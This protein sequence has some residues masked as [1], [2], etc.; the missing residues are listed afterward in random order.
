MKLDAARL[1]LDCEEIHE[2]Q[3]CPICSS[4]AFAYLT[5][6]IKPAVERDAE[7]RNAERPADPSPRAGYPRTSE[8]VE[9]YRQILE[10]KPRRR[11][12]LVTG[13]VLGLAAVSLAG[14]A[15][16]ASARKRSDQETTSSAAPAPTR[17]E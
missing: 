8:Q 17:E 15:I 6:W 10:G 4:E 3:I 9:A 1:C 2:S 12:G 13:G 5:R 11:S 7:R 14:W 16:R